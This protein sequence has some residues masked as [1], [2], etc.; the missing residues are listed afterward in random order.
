MLPT[1]GRAPTPARCCRG[2][3]EDARLLSFEIDPR[4]AGAV[5]NRIRE[6]RLTVLTASAEH[7][8][9][10]LGGSRPEVMVSALPFT[11]LPHGLGRTI[12]KR[13]A[14]A[15]APGGTLLV[16]AVL[17][18]HRGR[19]APGVRFV[20]TAHLPAEPS[21]C[22]PLRSPRPSGSHAS[23]TSVS[24]AVTRPSAAA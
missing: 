17:A 7:L 15:L 20:S 3:R 2:L 4:L 5:R 23:L 12:L 22:L 9:R 8:A 18:L 14:A 11:S 16:P 10:H 24:T 19:P 13:A 6:P 21:A 1:S